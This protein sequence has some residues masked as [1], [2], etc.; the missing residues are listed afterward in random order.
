VHVD[1]VWGK[2]TVTHTAIVCFACIIT[3]PVCVSSTVYHRLPSITPH[4]FIHIPGSRAVGTRLPTPQW[5]S[6]ESPGVDLE[7]VTQ[8][9][10]VIRLF[11]L[12]GIL[13]H[14]SFND[15]WWTFRAWLGRSTQM[16]WLLR[17]GKGSCINAIIW[18]NKDSNLLMWQHSQTVTNERRCE[19]SICIAKCHYILQ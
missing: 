14:F 19:D 13:P 16:L 18:S 11:Q 6:R 4:P 1:H 9:W 10:F 2:I 5:A 3:W 15:F 17:S 7:R 8:W 12:V